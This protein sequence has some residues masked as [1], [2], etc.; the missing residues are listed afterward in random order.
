MS[1]KAVDTDIYE[2]F[3]KT[4]KFISYKFLNNKVNF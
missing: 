4:S 1:I 3:A 2:I